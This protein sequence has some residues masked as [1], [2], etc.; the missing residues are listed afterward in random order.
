ML[1]QVLQQVYAATGAASDIYI[2]VRGYTD[3]GGGGGG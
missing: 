3:L 2:Y 1:Q